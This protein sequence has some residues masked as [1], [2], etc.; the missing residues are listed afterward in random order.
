MKKLISLLLALCCLCTFAACGA[1]PPEETGENQESADKTTISV[2][3]FN[4]G[5]G[6]VWL[7]EA[8]ER[9]AT[10]KKDVSYETGKTGVY[11]DVIE[12]G[13]IETTGLK[14]DARHIFIQERFFDVQQLAA[15]GVLYDISDV[16]TDTSREGGTLKDAIYDN[17][18]DALMYNGK[19][20]GLPH[21]EYYGGLSYDREV[22][23]KYNAYFAADDE[24]DVN[25]YT[26]EVIK[27]TKNFIGIEDAKKS[28]GPD[29]VYGTEDDGLP[30]TLEE[31]VLLMDYIKYQTPYAPVVVSGSY[32]N[33]TNYYLSGLWAAI[34]GY[35]QMTNYYNCSGEIEVV[36]GYYDAPL[37]P[38][39]DY[40]KKPKTEV[41]T[42]NGDENGY[43][44][45]EMAAKYYAI[46]IL[47]IMERSGFFS[48]DSTQGTVD[49][50]GAQKCLIYDGAAKYEEVAMLLEGSYWYNEAVNGKVFDSYKNVLGYKRNRDL[51]YMALPSAVYSTDE[52]KT[53]PSTLLDIG[54]AY[55]IVNGNIKGNTAIENAVKD[56]VAFLYSEQELKYFTM[57]TGMARSISYDLADDEKSEMPSFYAKLWELRKTDGSNVVYFSGT[58]STFKKV[59][60]LINI[61]LASQIF[62]SSSGK[63]YLTPM[64]NNSNKLESGEYAVGTRKMFESSKIDT[65]TWSTYI[66]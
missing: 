37:F 9:F 8:A 11:V 20:Y 41:I 13:V 24:T 61:H 56:F 22:F 28:V 2:V 23:D 10:L 25:A 48:K 44:G 51:R 1:K 66:K 16:V 58:T 40:I 47:E 35:Q 15:T 14:N 34:A 36:T 63:D 53:Q 65:G 57:S 60:H 39:I 4:G 46:A 12:S 5:I 17:A 55:L 21:Y 29:G 52:V 64:R 18:T 42:L 50:Y 7:H 43:R 49:H 45:N 31:F 30:R 6:T 32:L 27:L 3:N 19:Y 38:G 26:G 62:V 33:Y 54:Q 59:K